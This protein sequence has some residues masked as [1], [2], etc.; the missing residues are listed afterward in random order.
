MG[1]RK[2]VSG[3]RENV[4]NRCL[5]LS[6]AT[7]GSQGD[8]EVELL[9]DQFRP[10][11]RAEGRASGDAF[12][13]SRQ[14]RFG[15]R[16]LKMTEPESR[17]RDRPLTEY[18]SGELVLLLPMKQTRPS[19]LFRSSAQ[20]GSQSIAFDVPTD[21]Q[22]MVVFLNG[23]RFESPLVKVPRS[24]RS[25]MRV[26]ALSVSQGQP[27][28]EPRQ[29]P[30]LARPQ[31]QMPVIG[32]QAVRK[33]PHVASLASFPQHILK[34]RIIFR[35]MKHRRT[36]IRPVQRMKHHAAIICSFGSSHNPSKLATITPFRQLFGS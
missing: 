18:G 5:I 1:G 15:L 10:I 36:S 23:E 12:A 33:H 20:I 2:K 28:H 30:V 9:C 22:K 19:P 17:A 25:V 21:R 24:R 8:F 32:H 6:G 14:F 3:R 4:R 7:S 27:A 29:I 13:E 35:L 26:P 16:F 34:R 11:G 31:H